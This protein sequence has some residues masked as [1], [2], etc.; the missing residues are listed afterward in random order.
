MGKLTHRVRAGRP[1]RGRHDPAEAVGVVLSTVALALGVTTFTRDVRLLRRRWAGFEFAAIAAPFPAG[2]AAG[3]PRTRRRSTSPC[4][5]GEPR[6]SAPRSTG[7]CGRTGRRSPSPRSPTGCHPRPRRPRRTRSRGRLLFNGPVVGMRGDPLPATGARP[8]PIEL[9]RARFFDAVCAGMERELCE[10]SSLTRPRE[11][12][13]RLRTL[14]GTRREAG[15]SH[16]GRCRIGRRCSAER[17][18][19][20]TDPES[21]LAAASAGPARRGRV[22]GCPGPTNRAT[23]LFPE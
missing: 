4:P 8:A 18:T 21:R 20:A 14:D 5:P 10:E 16:G 13:G 17:G 12:A 22:A 9:H 7:T 23:P 3:P 2:P 6:W 11:P 19:P 1:A 15:V